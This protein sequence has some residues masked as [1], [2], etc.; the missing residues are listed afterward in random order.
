MVLGAAERLKEKGYNNVVVFEKMNRPGGMS[1]SKVYKAE[2]GKEIVY[3][4]GSVQPM[5]GSDLQKIIKKYKLEWGRGISI[6]ETKI[7]QI[8]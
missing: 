7:N 1:L 3:D 8:L 6:K 5:G 4:I 2:N